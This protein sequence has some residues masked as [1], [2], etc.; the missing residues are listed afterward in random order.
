M[1]SL[2]QRQ[3]ATKSQNDISEPGA[4][5][6]ALRAPSTAPGSAPTANAVDSDSEVVGKAVKRRNFSNAQKRRILAAADRCTRS[7]ELGALLRKEGVYSSSLSTW[8]R[9]R[10]SAELEALGAN[11][12]GPKVPANRAEV[13]QIAK[14]TREVGRLQGELDKAMLIIGVQKKLA[15]LLGR[16]IDDEIGNS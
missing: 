10:E 2:N 7:G 11:K 5:P 13:Q 8:R 9:Q 6:V 14:L 3:A 15:T 4:L 16:P 12:R 1:T